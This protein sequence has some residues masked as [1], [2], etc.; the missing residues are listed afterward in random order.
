MCALYHWLQL[1]CVKPFLKRHH[2]CFTAPASTYVVGWRYGEASVPFRGFRRRDWGA[3]R[4]VG[5]RRTRVRCLC[6]GDFGGDCHRRKDGQ[7]FGLEPSRQSAR[8][9]ADR[10]LE[11]HIV[12]A[13]DARG[14]RLLRTSVASTHQLRGA[15][16]SVSAR[17]RSNVDCPEIVKHHALGFEKCAPHVSGGF[18]HILRE[19]RDGYC[20]VH[21][22]GVCW[23][24]ALFWRRT[25]Y[26]NCN[27]PSWYLHLTFPPDS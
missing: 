3:S 9:R 8:L 17:V 13:A 25:G 12:A 21:H 5:G 1:V 4:S 16:L 26:L 7:L 2:T 11:M 19:W 24:R 23:S 10:C 20:N 18:A 6:P 22:G 14:N 27:K 15:I